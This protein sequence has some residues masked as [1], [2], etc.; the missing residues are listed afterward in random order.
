M[1]T[2]WAVIIGLYIGSNWCV[3]ILNYSDEYLNEFKDWIVKSR[4][5]FLLAVLMTVFAVISL[6]ALYRVIRTEY[7]RLN[8]QWQQ[9]N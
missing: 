7:R 8:N 1:T 9:V 2:Q 3:L 5:N 6:Y 4:K